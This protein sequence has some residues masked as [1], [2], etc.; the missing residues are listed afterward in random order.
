MCHSHLIPMSPWELDSVP[1]LKDDFYKGL[2]VISNMLEVTQ[3]D[4]IGAEIEALLVFP[5][6]HTCYPLC[7]ECS[8]PGF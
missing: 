3:P 5:L 7:L 2:G 8:Y 4:R 6:C 1:L